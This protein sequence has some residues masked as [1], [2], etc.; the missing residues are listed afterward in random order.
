[1]YNHVYLSE[2]EQLLEEQGITL[3]ESKE[4]KMIPVTAAEF[5]NRT[6]VICSARTIS[7]YKQIQVSEME[8]MAATALYRKTSIVSRL[9]ISTQ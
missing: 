5:K 4:K 1:M 8:A 2:E 7:D 9:Y 3:N 6:Y